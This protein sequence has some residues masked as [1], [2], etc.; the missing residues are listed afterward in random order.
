[1]L[2]ERTY[3]QKVAE[4]LALEDE[5][6]ALGAN[7]YRAER[8]L[9]WRTEAS[10]VNEEADLLP[11]KQLLKLC[12]DPVS[13]AIT[14]FVERTLNGG[15]GRRHDALYL[16]ANI[17]APEAAYLTA[18][19]VINCAAVGMTAQ[20]TAFQIADRIVHHIE[21]TLLQQ[22]NKPG[23]KGLVKASAR[24]K[25]GRK[26]QS[27]VAKLLL[28]EGCRIEVSQSQKLQTGMKCLEL[29][30]EVTGLFVIELAPMSKGSIYQVRPTEACRDWLERQHARCEVLEPIHMPMVIRPRR[31]RTPFRGGYLT[32][33]PGGKLVKQWNRQ[34]QDELRF[35]DMEPTYRA[36]N[37]IQ[38]TPW[39]INRRV[40]EVMEAVWDG[41]GSLG[42][43]PRR[44]DLPL[45][46]RPDDIDEDD[47]ALRRWK[48]DA[49]Q[50]HQRNA[51]ALSKRLALSQRLW[52]ARKFVEEEA[53]YFPHELD[54][55][56]RV[57]PTPTGGPTPQ[58]D[59]AA[60]ALLEFSAGLPL[61]EVGAWWLA[62]HIANLFGV[63]KVTFEERVQ[64]VW[65]NT[66]SILDSAQQ[67]LDGQRFWT[68]ADSP[69]CA[70]AACFEWQ[71]FIVE[72]ASY[73]SRVPVALDGSNSGLQHFSGMLL[74]PVGGRAVN[75]LPSDKPQD[76]YLEVAAAA[77]AVVDAS[78]DPDLAPWRGG[79]VTRKIA[80]RPCMTY[81]YSATRFGMVDMILSTLRELDADNESRGLPPHLEGADNYDAA[82]A[83]SYVLWDAIS[84]VVS[85][86][87]QAMAWLR[88]VAK[89]AAKSGQPIWW[90]TPTGLPVMQAYR[91]QSHRRIDVKYAG[92]VIKLTLV[93]DD[94]GIDG[95]AQANGIAPNFVH[96]FDAAH[97]MSVV[98][99]CA[100]Q[101]IT[102]LA[103]IHDSFGTHAANAGA[104]SETLRETFIQQ[105]SVDR[106]AMFREELVN[107]LPPEL[108]AEVP[109][110][111]TRGPL[112]LN[113]LRHAKYMF[114]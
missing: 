29:L 106:L 86:A 30:C 44:D 99:A 65:D 63:D 58:G 36:L 7:R 10:S 35:V 26:R 67:P 6:R 114:A 61:T 111:P 95:R 110:V 107:Q 85:A 79:K 56:G 57:Y 40:L 5:S 24:A 12:I 47:T 84:D 59:D 80:K 18:R 76:V 105:Y 93:K 46:P 97:L 3:R 21:M 4:Q 43:L 82:T 34:Y 39:R 31:W 16:L 98:N 22:N 104:L 13:S 112:D 64:W 17:G 74:D 8:P 83:L 103:V 1:M 66:P 60:K 101:G 92:K 113:A 81:C 45:P 28:K 14:E 51:E 2:D 52:V 62:V 87:S 37:T 70:L 55:R 50:V 27:A 20:A 19:A 23:F 88:D 53:I 109:E 32:K 49:A 90:T 69:Y 15:A 77:Q 89:V 94:E 96:S 9:P 75:L 41:G 72:G 108:A 11:G 71:G 48:A 54:F 33:R 102:S 73:V 91:T 68:S 25:T 100:E 78:G 38:D 42:G